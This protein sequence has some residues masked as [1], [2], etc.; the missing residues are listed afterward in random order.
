MSES[1]NE[2][3]IKVPDLPI[4]LPVF[5]G[6]LDLLLFLIR[7]N[8]LDIYDIPILQVTEQ[9]MEII[10]RMKQ[11]DL[12]VAGEFFVMASTL[13]YIKSRML[14]PRDE[15]GDVDDAAED[16]SIDPRWELVQQLI[17]YR[18]FKESAATLDDMIHEAQMIIAREV[19]YDE[20]DPTEERPLTQ[21]DR[22][23]VWGMFNQVLKRLSERM[24]VGEIHDEVVTVSDRM[25]YI[26][27]VLE[28]RSRFNFTDLFEQKITVS[29][30]ISTFIALL[31]LTRLNKI[32]I[33][34]ST[35]FGDIECSRLESDDHQ[36]PHIEY[37]TD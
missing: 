31:E 26:M 18:K 5:E 12:E 24:V 4:R 2:H 32:T 1:S 28:T 10:R 23:A 14:L 27:T 33:D 7:R 29:Y 36:R 8:E 15:Q 37:G 3:L 13:M 16:E 30:L 34:Q 11:K 19:Q 17:E 9:Y 22:I 6:P 35:P 21:T 25:E 20:S